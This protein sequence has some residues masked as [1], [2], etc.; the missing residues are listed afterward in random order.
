MFNGSKNF[1]PGTFDTTMEAA[2]GANNAYTSNDVTVYTNFI[3]TSALEITLDLEADRIRYLSVDPEVVESERGVVGSERRRSVEDSNYDLMEEQLYAAAY[4][5]HPYQWPVIGWRSDIESWRQR[6]V[7]QFFQDW[8]APNN[9]TMVLVGAF[10]SETIL[11]LLEK[12]IGSIPAREVPRG[13][14][15]TEPPQRGERR[16][17]LRKEASQPAVMIAWH[18]DETAHP[19]MR[20]L[21]LLDVILTSG[22]SSR[23]YRR[24]VD[25]DQL[26]LWCWTWAGNH[27][28]PGLFVATIQAREGIDGT[29]IEA[30]LYDE[31]ER[32]K[33]EPVPQDEL[34]K[35]K[36]VLLTGFFRGMATINGRA[37]ALVSYELFHG[38]F[39]ALFEAADTY[40]ALSAEDLMRVARKYFH[41]DNRT[42]VTLIPTGEEQEA[43]DAR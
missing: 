38:D 22:E 20:A 30:A 37:N 24:L 35:A 29:S 28:D 27:F 8:Y 17:V 2:G 42:V 14:V 31:L 18:V 23:L 33:S 9:A 12:K 15:T 25:T 32:V 3:P 11:P 41:E 5:A 21:E 36:N 39:R 6:D 1:P 13:V 16:V 19:D 40:G 34:D 26:A 43:E 4:M 10:D 7:E